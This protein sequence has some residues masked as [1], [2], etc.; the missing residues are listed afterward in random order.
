MIPL[1]PRP[2]RSDPAV[3]AE[4]AKKLAPKVLAWQCQDLD[5]FADDL[6]KIEADLAKAIVYQE[7][8]YAIAR[9]LDSYA[10]YSPDEQLVEILSEAYSAKYAAHE[11]A[12]AEWL[13]N[14]GLQA[15]KLESRVTSVKVPTGGV[16]I[17]IA[18]RDTG[19]ST[20]MFAELGHTRTGNGT[21]GRILNWEDLEPSAA[22][23]PAHLEASRGPGQE[24][25]FA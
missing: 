12:L 5:A 2:Q 8:G 16:G 18:N 9:N 4:A 6:P 23:L 11:K 13:P 20:V 1:I 15:P 19:T 22:P 14:A 21:H 10:G 25:P 7:D 24:D 3:I 17:V